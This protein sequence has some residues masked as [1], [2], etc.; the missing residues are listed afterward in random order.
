MSN[1]TKPAILLT[2][3]LALP[4]CKDVTEQTP[5][6]SDVV[7]D[8]TNITEA[9]E[10]KTFAALVPDSVIRKSIQEFLGQDRRDTWAGNT[11]ARHEVFKNELCEP[12]GDKC[13]VALY[14]AYS[15]SEWFFKNAGISVEADEPLDNARKIILDKARN[16]LRDPRLLLAFYQS[17]KEIIVEEL[18]KAAQTE[19]EKA[20][21]EEWLKGVEEGLR[22][23]D[24]P[25]FQK[26]YATYLATEKAWRETPSDDSAINE[27]YGTYSEAKE[28]LA[29][30]TPDLYA[31]LFAGRRAS[32]NPDVVDTYESI[33]S[34]LRGVVDQL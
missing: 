34:D 19:E 4:G 8:I 2:A 3:A 11:V 13:R 24:D 28:A 25:E 31:S 23:F 1:L 30:L 14:A 10:A 5:P 18:K 7:R 9:L 16:F 33:A 12:F 32:E 26:A 6:Q 15:G 17:K 22:A 20:Q 21:L 29:V 27:R